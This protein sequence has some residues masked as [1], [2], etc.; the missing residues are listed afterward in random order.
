METPPP[1]PSPSA[2]G[3]TAPESPP[4]RG[5][6]EVV[7]FLENALLPAV[8]HRTPRPVRDALRRAVREQQLTPLARLSG[9]HRHELLLLIEET[10][11]PPRRPAPGVLVRLTTVVSATSATPDLVGV[12]AARPAR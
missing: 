8:G 6:R 4:E 11:H 2:E 7:A 9:R 3:T 1:G 5:D 10:A 12:S